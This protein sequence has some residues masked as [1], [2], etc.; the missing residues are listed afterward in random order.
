MIQ[1]IEHKFDD[2][3]I[4]YGLLEF[5]IKS[6][7]VLTWVTRHVIVNTTTQRSKTVRMT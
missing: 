1:Y 2:V 3:V 6:Q 7:K 4:I 5:W